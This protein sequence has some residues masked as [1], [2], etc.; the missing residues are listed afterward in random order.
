MTMKTK[1][2]VK[3][4]KNAVKNSEPGFRSTFRSRS[5]A[6]T[7]A[8]V[9]SGFTLI[10]MMFAVALL[11]ILIAIAAPGFQNLLAQNRSETSINTLMLSL[12][13]AR[14]EAVKRNQFVTLC[15]SADG[16]VCTTSDNWEQGWLVFV[17]VDKDGAWDAAIPDDVLTPLI[18]ESED[19]E[20]VVRIEEA[21][22]NGFTLTSVTAAN[23]FSY[24]PDGSGRSSGGLVNGTF[25]LCPESG[26]EDDANRV[27]TNITGRPLVKEG[28]GSGSCP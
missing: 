6:G 11:A 19:A 15:K 12:N 22:E 4:T 9:V 2:V 3:K 24:R 23:W 18:D 7:Q 8:R 21:F 10:E 16:I 14:S 27:V 1:I 5:R 13:L 28:A 17:D 20:E 25:L 26:D